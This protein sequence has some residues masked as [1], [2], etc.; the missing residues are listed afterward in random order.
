MNQILQRFADL[1][2]CTTPV[3]LVNVAHLK[4]RCPPLFFS[5]CGAVSLSLLP[6]FSPVLLFLLLTLQGSDAVRGAGDVPVAFTTSSSF[7]K[8]STSAFNALDP[9][10]GPAPSCTN[11][12]ELI[13]VSFHLTGENETNNCICIHPRL[14]SP[15]NFE[16]CDTV[17]VDTRSPAVF[18]YGPF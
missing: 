2:M 4:H 7:R 1:K 6:H 3:E 15:Q 8:R 14:L 17:T 11:L 13:R 10:A 16:A 5:T 9:W 18:L 12:R